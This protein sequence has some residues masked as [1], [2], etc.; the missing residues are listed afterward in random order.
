MHREGE[1]KKTVRREGERSLPLV[2]TRR[3][4]GESSHSLVRSPVLSYLNA[5]IMISGFPGG[6]VFKKQTNKQTNKKTVCNSGVIGD[7]SLIPELGKSPGE[8]HSN[9]PQYSCLENPMD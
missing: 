3:R 8:G 6:S 5:T 2:R 1:E 7:V 4:E 9:P